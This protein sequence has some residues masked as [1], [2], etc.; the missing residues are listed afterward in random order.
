MNRT[1]PTVLVRIVSALLVSIAA[2]LSGCGSGASSSLSTP[3]TPASNTPDLGTIATVT[4]GSQ[5]KIKN[6]SSGQ[7]LGVTAQSQAAGALID[8]ASD[9]GTADQLWHFMPMGSNQFNVENLLT[10]QVAGI[11]N[12]STTT[13][14]IAVQWADNGTADHLWA[15]YLLTDGN[16]LIKNVNSN[17]YLQ[18]D[19][20][21]VPA[22]LDQAARATTGTGCTCQEWTLTST[23][24]SAYPAPLPVSGNG[25]FVHDPNMIQDPKSGVFW[26]YGTHNSVA[27][28]L[29][30]NTFTAA[31]SGDIAPDFTW[32]ATENITG[33]SGRTDIWA[34]SVMYA[35]GT[36]Y[37]YYSIPI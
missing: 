23:G 18:V 19:T 25:I 12:A 33:G 21:T 24:T 36:Y 20:S 5:F 9:T 4:D 11:A 16:Y 8:Q 30:M 3:S 35:N 26:L 7:L 37:Q 13:G 2:C 22:S 14:A 32:W 28:S 29:D 17:L 31:T 1:E 15:F 10:H 34:P 6:L 27:S